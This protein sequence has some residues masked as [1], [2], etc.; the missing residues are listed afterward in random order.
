MSNYSRSPGES[1][2]S[3]GPSPTLADFCWADPPFS[4]PSVPG[5]H[6]RLLIAGGKQWGA[7]GRAPG[8][9]SAA[10]PPARGPWPRCHICGQS[11]T[12]M[13][14]KKAEL[15]FFSCLVESTA[16]KCRKP[17]RVLPSKEP[18]A[19]GA[20]LSGGRCTSSSQCQME[21]VQKD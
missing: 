12:H 5:A 2:A 6:P 14:R 18:S 19:A 8:C 11:G 21:G 17:A 3:R 10:S 9:P 15:A 13:H 20:Q 4:V 7:P 16:G 1:V